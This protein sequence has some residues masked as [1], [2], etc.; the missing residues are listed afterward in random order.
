MKVLYLGSNEKKNA[1]KEQGQDGSKICWKEVENQQFE[2]KMLKGNLI[3]WI[4]Y[5]WNIEKWILRNLISLIFLNEE[6]E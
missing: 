4:K 3:I 6:V 1:G 5:R 2:H